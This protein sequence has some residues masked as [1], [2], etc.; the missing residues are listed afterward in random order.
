MNS[1]L[2]A[3]P[4]YTIEE[5]ITRTVRVIV[6]RA[7]ENYSGKLVAAKLL[8]NDAEGHR[9]VSLLRRVMAANTPRAVHV[10]ELKHVYEDR[11]NLWVMVEYFD[12][13]LLDLRPAEMTPLAL[14]SIALDSAKGL[15]EMYRARVI[16]DDVKP[17]NIA[18][19]HGSGRAA[20]IDLGCARVIGEKVAG[21]T[22]EYVAP[23]IEAGHPSDTSPCYSWARTMEQIVTGK[24]GL[25]PR[26]LLSDYVP[27]VGRTFSR[28]VAQCCLEN[29]H[30]RPHM[31]ELYDLVKREI[32]EKTR[33]PRCNAIRFRDGSC[34]CCG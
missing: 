27:W 29:P 24:F 19:K 32:Q 23:E 31:T 25:G 26:D 22:P 2:N 34:V 17:G 14:M 5:E 6:Y 11:D 4:G 7:T 9:E 10:V 18:F 21:Y 8:R 15:V 12:S 20:H 30:R 33:C 1:F 13:T 3:V 16:D 28:F